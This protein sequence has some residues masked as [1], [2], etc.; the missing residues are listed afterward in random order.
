MD[1]IEQWGG[2]A[3]K[4]GCVQFLHGSQA[5]GVSLAAYPVDSSLT[6]VDRDFRAEFRD[7]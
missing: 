2:V 6:I 4:D 5:A 7:R 1:A 3:V